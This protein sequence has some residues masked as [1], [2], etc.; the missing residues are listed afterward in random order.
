[1]ISLTQALDYFTEAEELSQQSREM[2]ER[3]R[4]Y[5][6]HKQWTPTEAE[7][8]RKRKQPVITR[9]RIKPKVDYLKGAEIQTR[10]D[11]KAAARTPGDENAAQVA[12]DAVRYVYD[13]TRF[14]KI[15]S[16][17]F[18]N[19]T[20]EGTGGVEVYVKPSRDNEMDICIRRYQWDRLGWDP[21]SRERDFSDSTYRYA[22]AWMD[23]EQAVDRYPGKNEAL[24]NTVSMEGA[25][26]DTYD[27]APRYRWTD[28]KRKRVRVVKLEYLHKNEV[29]VCEFTKGGFLAEPEPSPYVDDSGIPEWSI[30]L[31]S[32]HVDRNGNRYGYVHAWLDIQ[33]EINKR[34]SKHLHLVSV[35][36]TYSTEGASEDI[37]KLKQELAKPDGHLKFQRGEYG[38]D[39][40]VLPTMDQAGAQ[41]Q[42]LQEAKQEIDSVGVNAALSGAEERDLSGNAIRK[43]QQGASTEL[44]PLFEAISQFDNQVCRAVWNRIKQFWTAEKWIRVTGDDDAP[45]WI[46]INIP[47]T[48]GEQ[49]Q[50]EQGGIPPE[51]ADDPRLNM[52]A[53]V[54]NNI[55]EI[56][57]DFIIVE[58]PDT[59]NSMQEQFEALTAIYP[60]IPDDKKGAAF[61]MLVEASSLPNKKKV[62]DRFKGD[63]DDPA[64]Q[65][66]TAMAERMA[67]L[68]AALAEAK[69]ELTKAQAENQKAMSV[70][71]NIE[72]LYGAIQAAQVA[73][74]VPGVV[75]AA[76]EIAKSGGFV[77]KN[78]APLYPQP[79]PPAAAAM[80]I[81]QD[82]NTSP[83][84][85]GRPDTP[86]QGFNEGIETQRLDGVM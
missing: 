47:V 5:Y 54:K 66:A 79:Q 18:E 26:S 56:D 80:P 69:V 73:V 62:L 63:D 85:P 4:D 9:N 72:G 60:H 58:V 7:T 36:Q 23:Y 25:V 14:P 42:L 49:L 78:Q 41:F 64:T 29:Y 27:D 81:V 46:G 67:E 53:G 51:I 16:D 52:V 28:N 3:C 31:Q 76:D 57:V 82:A 15:K 44:K 6:D 71:K 13:R 34:A 39:F 21:H 43:L 22:I 8:L 35:R 75:P 50:E 40:G 11:P 48:V 2:S 61:E 59:V 1:M 38:K 70:V 77:D 68:Q 24:E 10:T 33:D 37:Q 30:I 83:M 55:A 65:K 86:T 74:T 17:V 20:I 45:K 12:T 84:F 19:L 32:A